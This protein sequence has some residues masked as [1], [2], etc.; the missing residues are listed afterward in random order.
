MKTENLKVLLIIEQCNPEWASVP[1][2]GYRYY[3]EISRRVNTTLVT[4]QRNQPALQKISEHQDIIYLSESSWTKSYY[5]FVSGLTTKGRTNWPLLNTLSYPIYAE[6][7][8]KVY[9]KF[10]TP[11]QKGKYDLV[12]AITPM[13]PRYPY[14]IVQACQKTPFLLGPVNGG[15]PFPA[16]FEEVAKQE[17][18]YLNFLRA[19]GRYVVPGYVKTYKQADKI[20]SG[21][22]YTL[23]LIKNLFSLPD[24]K[25][26]LFYENGITEN[27]LVSE[28]KTSSNDSINLLFVGRLVPY[29]GADMLIESIYKLD[30]SIR[31]KV[32]L[33]IVGDGSEKEF[34]EKRVQDLQLNHIV[35]FTGWVSQ[36]ETCNYYQQSDVFCFPSIREFG[37]AVVIEAM[38]SGLPCIVVNNGGIGEY[39]TEDTGFKIEPKSKGFVVDEL[40]KKITL[41]VNRN[42]LRQNMSAKAIKRAKEFLWQN[43]AQKLIEIYQELVELS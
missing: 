7:N 1:L 21:S 4:H 40:A 20:L 32:K 34:L 31:N 42:D 11:V 18:A 23:N 3:Q 26:Q 35:N 39:V 25:L 30:S 12:H 6:F 16:G 5:K 33:T 37:G 8:N 36:Q 28:P 17:F 10:K 22:T 2:V 43:K 15:V 13:M 24:S 38:A 19:I 9:A 14:K 29:K 41:L 27:F